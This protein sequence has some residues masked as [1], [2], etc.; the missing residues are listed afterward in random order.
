MHRSPPVA[1]AVLLP[2]QR[3]GRGFARS[4]DRGEFIA[5]PGNVVRQ[6]GAYRWHRADMSEAHAL[7]AVADGRLRVTTPEGEVLDI[8]YDRHIEHASGDW[9][10]IGHLPDHEGVQTILTF[11]AE[12][13]F[14][15]IARPGKLPLRLTVRD[16]VSWLVETDPAKVAAIV[17]AATRPRKRD[18]HLVPSSP[19]IGAGTDGADIGAALPD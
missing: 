9:T 6:E 3:V 5:Y 11:G 16:G 18:Y 15:S 14:G 1:S 2:S 7:R 10:W 19:Y 12:A 8:R 4:P 13:A 17:N